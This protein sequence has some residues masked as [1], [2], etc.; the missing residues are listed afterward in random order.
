MLLST[1]AKKI[2]DLII[3]SEGD[4]AAEAYYKWEA[5]LNRSAA[6][7]FIGGET[8]VLVKSRAIHYQ[9]RHYIT[10]ANVP[11]HMTNT[12]EPVSEDLARQGQNPINFDWL[13]R[14][15]C[16]L[17]AVEDMMAFV[18][19]K[20]PFGT[21]FVL[22]DLPDLPY[23]DVDAAVFQAAAEKADGKLQAALSAAAKVLNDNGNQW[24]RSVEN[25]LYDAYGLP[26]PL[27]NG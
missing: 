21:Y 12:S 19:A 9:T 11:Y 7:T 15:V 6:A 23:L 1:M 5:Q 13:I 20:E 27:T 22:N 25:T 14:G 24:D 17:K 8:M 10:G 3:S 16:G 2:D 18:R 26:H 4:A